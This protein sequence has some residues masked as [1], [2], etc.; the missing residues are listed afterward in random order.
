MLSLVAFGSFFLI[1]S[2]CQ[3]IFSFMGFHRNLSFRL[4]VFLH[5]QLFWDHELCVHPSKKEG[6]KETVLLAS[7]P[8]SGV[9]FKEVRMC[10][11]KVCIVCAAWQCIRN[12]N[13]FI[14]DTS[15]SSSSHLNWHR[16]IHPSSWEDED[17]NFWRIEWGSR[18]TRQPHIIGGA[19]PAAGVAADCHLHDVKN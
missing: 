19:H 13:Q 6:A 8:F 14:A 4:K 7:F 17:M 18:P 2:I 16:Y 12:Q 11:H 3:D 9:P 5:S 15:R 10:Q 1:R